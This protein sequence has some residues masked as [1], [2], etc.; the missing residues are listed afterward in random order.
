MKNRCIVYTI[1]IIALLIIA[2]VPEES[3]A[4]LGGPCGG[5]HFDKT[6]GQGTPLLMVTLGDS[7]IWGQGHKLGEDF[8]SQIQKWISQQQ[9]GYAVRKL[10]Y[11]HS[12]ATIDPIGEDYHEGLHGEINWSTPT[13]TQQ[14]DCVPKD[15]AAKTDLVLMDGCINDFNMRSLLKS[16]VDSA[17]IRAYVQTSC[18]KRMSH[19]LRN[20]T[21]KFPNA[22]VIVTGYFPLISPLSESK[23]VGQL[24]S[25]FSIP[26]VGQIVGSV[27]HNHLSAN[28]KEFYTASNEALQAAVAEQASQRVVFIPIP[29]G[30]E[31]AFG[32]PQSYLYGFPDLQKR[33]PVFGGRQV[34]CRDFYGF[35][36][37]ENFSLVVCM[38]AS[39]FH[40]K[41][42]GVAAYRDAILPV[43]NMALGKPC[44][45]GGTRNKF[46]CSYGTGPWAGYVDFNVVPEQIPACQEQGMRLEARDDAG[47]VFQG[48]SVFI[49]GSYFGTLN[50]DKQYALRLPGTVAVERPG[51]VTLRGELGKFIRPMPLYVA[52]KTD[53]EPKPITRGELASK[54]NEA[55][56]LWVYAAQDPEFR[57]PVELTI[58]NSI[59]GRTYR[60]NQLI[61]TTVGEIYVADA[62]D[63]D[64]I[65]SFEVPDA[66]DPGIEPFELETDPKRK[67]AR[68]R[69][70]QRQPSNVEAN[71]KAAELRERQK[72]QPRALFNSWAMISDCHQSTD[73]KSISPIKPEQLAN[74]TEALQRPLAQIPPAAPADLLAE[75]HVDR[76]GMDYKDFDLPQLGWCQAECVKD[77]QCQAFTFSQLGA[78]FSQA[79][80]W[81]KRGISSPIART[82]FISGTK[83]NSSGAASGGNLSPTPEGGAAPIGTALG[84]LEIDVDRFGMDYK[85]FDSPQPQHCQAQCAGD[86][87]CKAFTFSQPGAV[88]PGGHCWLKNNVPPKT[89]RMGFISGTNPAP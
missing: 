77:P 39:S 85:D 8:A 5:A 63:S 27:V 29:F 78:V 26:I 19:L 52:Y 83:K 73:L 58:K 79:H 11:A 1:L 31:N 57:Q 59:T 41:P 24:L 45:Y 66:S 69:E 55:R 34:A 22:L 18:T 68:L 61:T 65:E 30:P 49:N 75:L 28:S 80:C 72:K 89:P 74:V 53:F 64:S 10:V 13:I 60:A 42:Q 71:K 37:V 86:P 14:V 33:D 4:T 43:L 7:V 6:E 2:I 81:L 54:W 62:S 48:G 36:P 50:Q 17:W 76:P 16:E 15:V 51:D 35:S 23:Q 84:Q 20:V 3:E 9:Q 25:T 46:V 40:P 87:Q 21:R 38:L 88:F 32:A 67:A 56:N 44:P 82:G 12:G 47:Q 70:R